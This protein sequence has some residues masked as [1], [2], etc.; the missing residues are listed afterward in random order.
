[1]RSPEGRP[2]RRARIGA[3]MAAL[4]A[5]AGVMASLAACSSGSGATQAPATVTLPS[6]F[7]R[8]GGTAYAFGLPAQPHFVEQAE[9]VRDFGI[10]VRTWV[11]DLG[12]GD[13]DKPQ[14]DVQAF[15]QP[16]YT[17]AFPAAAIALYS[18]PDVP[19][20]KILRNEALKPAPAGAVAAVQQEATMSATLP[21]GRVVTAHQWQRQYLLPGRGLVSLTVTV[22]DEA[23]SLCPG[24]QIVSTLQ[25]TGKP[26]PT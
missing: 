15:E 20:Q 12:P 9:S 23:A 24:A 16:S 17:A 5:S 14:C 6:G 10:R 4:A 7:V 11:Y 26:P 3:A 21:S 25:V 18:V 2:Q 13:N 1:M 22:P 19:D 8:A